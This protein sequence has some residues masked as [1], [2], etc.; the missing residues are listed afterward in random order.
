MSRNRRNKRDKRK[1]INYYSK[2]IKVTL[3]ITIMLICIIVLGIK[4][5]KTNDIRKHQEASNNEI[6]NANI[7][8]TEEEKNEISQETKKDVTLSINVV[9]NILCENN[10]LNSTSKND[11]NFSNIFE[12]IEKHTNNADLTI[13]PLETNF[14]NQEYSG[15]VRYNSPITLVKEMK[16]I[17]ID[18]VFLANNH[19]MDY[20]ING[21]K[22]TI[23]NIK[24]TGIELVGAKDD[25]NENNI[26]I[27]EY[28][29]IKIAF[30]S[31]TYGTNKKEDGYE[32]YVNLINKEVIQNDILKAKEEGVEYIIVGMHWGNAFGDKITETQKEL[33]D[34]LVNSGVDIIIG[35]H[36]STIQKMETRVNNEGKDVLIVNSIGNFISSEDSKNSM[37][38]MVL[39]IELVKL[40]E[41]DKVYLNKVSYVP[42]YIYDAGINAENRYKILDVKEEISN[43][44]NGINNI[45]EKTYK[46][47]KQGLIKIKELING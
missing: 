47:L 20:G 16:N 43:Y 42:T 26:L 36:P 25:E 40:A 2:H 6:F 17:G 23:K 8:L 45:D 13:A 14:I 3:P 22:E 7:E 35:N 24:E 18:T 34:F 10:V 31:Y 4:I 12:Y 27:K 15:N 11:Y 28:R 37:L 38:G 32:K 44:E 5:Y 21:I 9:G 46:K 39:K 29:N 1:F 33:S 41:D 30:L 19:L